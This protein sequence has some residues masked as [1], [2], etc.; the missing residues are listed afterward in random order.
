MTSQSG[1]SH[2]VLDQTGSVAAFNMPHWIGKSI[3]QGAFI[4][5][6]NEMVDM[7]VKLSLDHNVPLGIEWMD[8]QGSHH[9]LLSESI[10]RRSTSNVRAA[11]ALVKHAPF[12]QCARMVKKHL[13]QMLSDY[14]QIIEDALSENQLVFEVCQLKVHPDYLDPTI[15]RD[16]AIHITTVD[17]ITE[18]KLDQD[19]EKAGERWK[20]EL[21]EEV[22]SLE[23]KA[24]K[25]RELASLH[26]ICIEDAAGI[27]M[28]GL[29]RPL[30]MSAAPARIFKSATVKWTVLWKWFNIWKPRF[31]KMAIRYGV[32]LITFTA[33]G[34]AIGTRHDLA[35][36]NWVFYTVSG[37]L[38]SVIFAFGCDMIAEEIR[39]LMSYTRD[40]R[41]Y[42]KDPWWGMRYFLE[43]SW[44]WVDV[45]SSFI[46]LVPIPVFHVLTCAGY[47]FN[48]WLLA[49]VAFEAIIAS[50]KAQP[51][52]CCSQRLGCFCRSGILPN[53][54]E[55]QGHWF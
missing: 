46:L 55:I 10:Q 50:I 31:L 42:L 6:D 14:P 43:S 4:R 48:D 5:T 52:N 12:M 34:V 15:K 30:L 21:Y 38:L 36:Q 25:P 40:G 41:Q 7:V 2:R 51:P 22:M 32:F 3:F 35:K 11:L 49:T 33:Y 13:R 8:N 23:R 17:T 29:I 54:S 16:T 27:G 19:P 37:V 24:D 39:Q 28:N 47:G 18:W 53:R 26:A 20:R 1:F 44:N 45:T 9:S